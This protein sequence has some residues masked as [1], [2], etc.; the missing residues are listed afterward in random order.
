MGSNLIRGAWCISVDQLEILA[1][2]LPPL[3]NE[4][5]QRRLYMNGL[6]GHHKPLEMAWVDVS[7]DERAHS[8][9]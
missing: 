5:H 3:G 6:K 1:S 9:T 7:L 8:P 2:G 4:V